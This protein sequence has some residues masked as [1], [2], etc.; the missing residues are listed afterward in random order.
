M[1]TTTAA[2]STTQVHECSPSNIKVVSDIKILCVAAGYAVNSTT[3]TEIPDLTTTQTAEDRIRELLLD[4]QE[5]LEEHN[6]NDLEKQENEKRHNVSQQLEQKLEK[7][8][9]EQQSQT[10]RLQQELEKLQLKQDETR[11]LQVTLQEE[12]QNQIRELQAQLLMLLQKIQILLPTEAPTTMEIAPMNQ[13]ENSTLFYSSTTMATGNTTKFTFKS[14]YNRTNTITKKVEVV[15][16][17]HNAYIGMGFLS[18]VAGEV[19]VMLVMDFFTIWSQLQMCMTN[20]KA[21]DP[22]AVIPF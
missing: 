1:P 13:T 22:N 9:Q 18:L 20:I 15:E 16:S 2:E 21:A 8:Q 10:Q 3:T 19:A 5:K 6:K 12:Q 14:I 11:Q 17:P 4:I 7:L